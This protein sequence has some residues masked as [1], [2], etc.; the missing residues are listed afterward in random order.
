M[1]VN[2]IADVFKTSSVSSPLVAKIDSRCRRC[3]REGER[4]V[5]IRV[6]DKC[7]R[8]LPCRGARAHALARTPPARTRTSAPWPLMSFCADALRACL[9]RLPS[10]F[11]PG[12]VA[13]SLL[14]RPAAA[15]A[16][17]LCP[18]SPRPPL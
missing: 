5:S 2:G 16:L 13:K 7:M 11:R 12:R 6:D 14:D 4:N 3:G 8:L 9:P 15:T 10:P 18:L 17:R 1:A